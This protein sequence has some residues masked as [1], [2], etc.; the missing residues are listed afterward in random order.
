MIQDS[1]PRRTRPRPGFTLVEVL[2]TLCLLVI[3]AALA[4]PVLEKP[5]ANL[6]LRK[7][8][9]RIRARWCA[10]RVDAMG[11][12]QT[13]VFRYVP[14]E[15]RFR[16]ERRDV[17][18]T[19]D[20]PALDDSSPGLAVAGGYQATGGYEPGPQQREDVLPQGVI[21]LGS[22]TETDARAA[23]IQSQDESSSVLDAEWSE[24]I[25]FYSDGTTSTT[26][27]SL[28][29]EHGRSIELSLRGLTGVVEV[30]EIQRGEE[31]LP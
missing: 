24:P 23:M 31:R 7:A 5:L 20:D 2:L 30:G 18:C 11:S 14:G 15:N 27:L 29:N 16:I 12:G 9:D 6:R 1:R 26:R 22:E 13:Y 17:D 28:Q 3:V 10:A 8:A 4:W 21:F 25:L 19:A